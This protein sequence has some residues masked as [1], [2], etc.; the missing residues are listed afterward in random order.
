MNLVQRETVVHAIG[1]KI[2]V[3]TFPARALYQV[4]DIKIKAMSEVVCHGCQWCD[5]VIHM[6]SV[7]FSARAILNASLDLSVFMISIPG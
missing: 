6:P 3:Y 4:A 1:K 7:P 2:A 5:S